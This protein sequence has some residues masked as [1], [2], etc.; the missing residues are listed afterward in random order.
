M[1]ASVRRMGNR[2]G[3]GE[4]TSILVPDTVNGVQLRY[5]DVV[6]ARLMADDSGT[7]LDQHFL[8]RA[9]SNVAATPDGTISFG[10]PSFSGTPNHIA[11]Y[12]VN[13]LADG[14]Q[15]DPAYHSACWTVEHDYNDGS[16]RL[17]ELY[18][19]YRKLSNGAEVR[20]IFIVWNRTADTV[21]IDL[22]GDNYNFKDRSTGH[23]W[24]A[25]SGNSFTFSSPAGADYSLS[26]TAPASQTANLYVRGGTTHPYRIEATNDQV[27]TKY[28]SG[29]TIYQRFYRASGGLGGIPVQV[30]GPRDVNDAAQ[31]IFTAGDVSAPLAA[32][33]AWTSQA[34]D[35]TRWINS[36][37][38]TARAINADA[39][40]V[41][42]VTAVT[43]TGL[44]LASAAPLVRDFNNVTGATGA[45]GTGVR[46][47]SSA[48]RSIT[49]VNNDPDILRVYPPSGGTINGGTINSPVNAPANRAVVFHSTAAGTWFTTGL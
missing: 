13:E 18:C 3:G 23:V 32:F 45:A 15:V 46:L 10:V 29:G 41:M 30:F 34:G 20:P 19:G 49:V 4:A 25:R 42:A 33:R 44:D 7:G 36:S 47:P 37:G 8:V 11:K 5:G 6:V 1:A 22:T 39:D 28:G 17:T 43:A 2:S 35:L 27:Q 9:P 21:Q 24:G 16:N 48:G 26:V 38:S 12:G 14:S 40:Q 31:I